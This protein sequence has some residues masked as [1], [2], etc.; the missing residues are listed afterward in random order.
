MSDR[1]DSDFLQDI[2]QAVENVNEYSGNMTYSQF[3]KDKKTKDAVVRNLEIIGEAAKNIS[4]K[5]KKANP[6]IPWKQLAGMRDKIAHFYFGIDYKI[7]W[8][9]V[10][11]DMPN[12]NKEI[13]KIEKEND[14][15]GGLE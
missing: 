8:S 10:E 4:S 6:L 5:F 7:V 9:V 1:K 14:L 15:R 3:L 11:K 13:A 2:K 12:L